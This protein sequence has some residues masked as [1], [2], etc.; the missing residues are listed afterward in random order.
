MSLLRVSRFSASAGRKPPRA[1]RKK[2]PAKQEW[3]STIHD[4][5]VHRATPEDL[6]RRHEMHKSKNKALAHLELQEKT[7]KS[8]WK[9]QR[10]RVPESLEKRKLT[11]MRE[12][13]SDQYQLQDVLERSDQ[14]MAVVKDLFGDAPRRHIG[15]PNVTVAPDCDEESFQGPIIQKCDP[16]TQLSLLNESVMDSQALNE[17]EGE[18]SSICHTDCENGQ[19]V[20][21]NFGSDIGTDRKLKR[22]NAVAK[23]QQEATKLQATTHSSQDVNILATPTTIFQSMGYRALNA[24]HAVKKVHSRLQDEEQTPDV[25]YIVQQVLNANLRKQK[26]MSK[27]VKKK[28]SAQT[29]ARQKRSHS[30]TASTSSDHSNDNKSSLDVLNQM[31]HDVEHEMEEYEQRTGHE[32]QKTLNSQGVTGFTYSL[33]NALCRVMRFLKQ[34]EMR[35]CQE[36]LNR[37]QLENELSEHRALIDALTAEV[38]LVR[39]ENL[40]I[41]SKLQQYMV[42]TDEQLISFTHA[43]KGLS[44][45]DSNR[46]KSPGESGEFSTRSPEVTHGIEKPHLNYAGP[47]TDIFKSE[48]VFELSQS[49]LSS[50]GPVLPNQPDSIGV[51]QMLSTC[52]FQPAVLLSPPQQKNSEVLLSLPDESTGRDDLQK[53]MA[54]LTL[55]NSVVKAQLSKFRH[56]HQEAENSLQ[57]PVT[58]QNELVGEE[59]EIDRAINSSEEL[60][61]SLDERIAELNRQSAEARDKLL[62]L[63]KQQKLATL[64]SV[65]PPISPIPSPPVNLT[66]NGR[67]TIE[68]CIPVAEMLHSSKEDMTPPASRTNARRMEVYKKRSNSSFSL[69]FVSTDLLQVCLTRCIY[70]KAPH[71]EMYN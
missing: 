32:V 16:P 33:V 42:V 70:H 25:R 71:R 58:M 49:N 28:Q 34:S 7:L 63:I 19:D 55:Q 4:L 20:S 2:P 67:R 37:Q 47:K 65:S 3:D 27:K 23:C 44:A 36:T 45:T 31:M 60:P 14:A 61:K 52:T 53:Q 5:T 50:K 48:K 1:R 21:L 15:F 43:I 69:P 17:V 26:Q 35:L 46:I 41:Q 40:A 38:L 64:I 22:G 66:E 57:Q 9:K 12:I 62:F 30:N 54:E 29:P 11:L 13:L 6:V 8:K 10:L 51:G 68:V 24:T 18:S 59:P 39:E 56:Y